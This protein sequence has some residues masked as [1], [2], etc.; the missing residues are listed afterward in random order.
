MERATMSSSEARELLER[1]DIAYK[2]EFYRDQC[3]IQAEWP[4]LRALVEK[5]IEAEESVNAEAEA[6]IK[7]ALEQRDT[8][9][10]ARDTAQ[11]RVRELEADKDRLLGDFKQHTKCFCPWWVIND[12]SGLCDRCKIIDTARQKEQG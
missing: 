7:L 12:R 10:E 5:G 4:T 2:T 6:A 3:S 1:L 9:W 11:A 8:F